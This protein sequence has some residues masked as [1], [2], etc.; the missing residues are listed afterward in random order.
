M[1]CRLHYACIGFLLSTGCLFSMYQQENQQSKLLKKEAQLIGYM[2][3]VMGG[4]WNP[5]EEDNNLIYEYDCQVNNSSKANS[6]L[7]KEYGYRLAA[8]IKRMSTK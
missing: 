6:D 7:L 5:T 3:V 1:N 8:Y 2:P 4:E